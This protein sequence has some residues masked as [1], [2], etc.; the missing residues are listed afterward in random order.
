[1]VAK[2]ASESPFVGIAATAIAEAIERSSDSQGV[3]EAGTRAIQAGAGLIETGGNPD[4]A[5]KALRVLARFLAWRASE[6]EE[7]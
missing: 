3:I 6:I 2:G 7:R 5:A 4:E 1:M